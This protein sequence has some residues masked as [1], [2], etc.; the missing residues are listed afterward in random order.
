LDGGEEHLC[1]GVLGIVLEWR[2]E[3]L[4]RDT[5]LLDV[6]EVWLEHALWCLEPLLADLNDTAIG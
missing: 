6:Y 3:L 1:R 2:K 5:A 4:T